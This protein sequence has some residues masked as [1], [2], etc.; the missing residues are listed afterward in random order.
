MILYSTGT[1]RILIPSERA[2]VM[3]TTA[4]SLRYLH[5]HTLYVQPSAFTFNDDQ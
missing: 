3:R 4:D 1:D 5:R 2:V